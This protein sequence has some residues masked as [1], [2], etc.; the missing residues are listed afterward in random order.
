MFNSS[1]NSHVYWDT[2]YII[3]QIIQIHLYVLVRNLP[4]EAG[5]A[6]IR[7]GFPLLLSLV[8]DTLSNFTWE[9]GLG[10]A[11]LVYYTLKSRL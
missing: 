6:I 1:L 4:Q 2:L 10:T 8:G 9:N 11:R 7:K 3:Q 5:R